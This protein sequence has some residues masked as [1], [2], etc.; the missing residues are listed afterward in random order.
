M[1]VIAVVG[2]GITG[3]ALAHRLR[4]RG[5]DAV[6]LEAGAHLGGVIQTRQRDGFST[7]TGP[8]SFLDREPATRELAAS[9]GIEE[10]I[11]MADPSAKSRS[12]YTRGQLRPVPASPPA[13]L[14]SDL[15]PLGT[16]LRVLAELFTGRAPPGQDE[17]LGD[18]GRRHVGA[19]ATSVLLD[20]M[21]TGTY[22]GDVEALSA[23]AAFPT[24]KQLEREH[25]S[26][27]LG[28]VR[29]QGR[30]RAPAPAGTKLKGAMCTFEGGLG[31]LVEAL[32]RALGPAARTGAAVEGLAR[33]QNGW[34]LSV[35]E[36]GQQ[37]ELEASQ[38]VL[39]S[40]A[41]V[42]AELLAP[43]DPSL[44]GHLKGIPYAPIAVVHLGFAPGKTPPPDGFGFLVPGQEQRQLLGVIHVSTVFPFRAE[45]G[46]VLYTCLMGGAR[47][48]DLVGLNEEALAALA[49]Q[50]L[51]E[52]A[53]VTASPDFTE[54]VRWP[55]GIP[56]YTVGHLERLSAI[57]SALARLP[58]LHLAGN[59]YKG[60]GLNDC[61]RNAAALAET[62]ASR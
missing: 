6:V 37:A 29:T 56:Q 34:R 49:Q 35:R 33:S 36:R 44:A 54:A 41:H 45:G 3:L 38:V 21:Q 8:N 20:A 2:G 58:G 51:R 11:R 5:K 47:R 48:P 15:L 12:L 16:R 57:D 52:M 59:A 31:T 19:R 23:E 13:F 9:L 53:G 4:S 42:S 26:L 7:E 61:I 24:L 55:R 60:V 1:A 27:L 30:Q 17:S 46:R 25:R 50:E 18:F 43:L 22:A 10:R 39:T 32:A 40:P 14:K 28:A 62:L